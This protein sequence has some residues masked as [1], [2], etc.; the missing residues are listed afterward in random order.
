MRNGTIKLVTLLIGLNVTRAFAASDQAFEA[1]QGLKGKWAI[2]SQGEIL[3]MDM[4]YET[5]SKNSV[6]TEQFG[7][8]LSV[9]SRQGDQ[10]IMSHYC[11]AGNQ[12]R[13]KLLSSNAPGVFTF[14]TVEVV[15]L[16]SKNTPYVQKIIYHLPDA[17]HIEL[18]LV[19]KKGTSTES[20]K[21]SLT[22]I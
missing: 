1:F 13:L 16:K 4:T 7:K 12:P 2:Q 18:E 14:E 19:W 10:V 3:P 8:E 15:N 11:N 20:E 22:K 6:I 21:Y 5:A 9:I 17:T